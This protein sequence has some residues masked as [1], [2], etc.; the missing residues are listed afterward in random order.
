M[1]MRSSGKSLRESVRTHFIVTTGQLVEYMAH[2]VCYGNV[3][4]AALCLVTFPTSLRT[5]ATHFL[6]P[7]R[8]AATKVPKIESEGCVS[9]SGG[10]WNGGRASP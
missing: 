6:Q 10:G 9:G 4:A 7:T 8:P 5:S 3:G 2:E 1:Y